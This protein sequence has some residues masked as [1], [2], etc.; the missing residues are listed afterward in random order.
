MTII[1]EIYEADESIPADLRAMRRFARLMDEA[2]A[3]PGTTKR[4]GLDAALGVIPGV[5][6]AAGAL[7]SLWILVG[8][9]RHRVP[10][11]VFMKMLGAVLLDLVVGSIPF[12]GDIFD[13]LF[14]ENV[15]NVELVVKHRNRQVPPRGMKEA[16][17]GMAV[18]L[19]ALLALFAVILAV[20]VVIAIIA[21]RS[22]V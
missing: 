11:R 19:M 17:V 8:A 18:G 15:A 3:I 5:G 21:L 7:F 12:L 22:R 13:V 1:P 20:I 10:M 16:G 9:I 6:D 2:V 4:I 14:R